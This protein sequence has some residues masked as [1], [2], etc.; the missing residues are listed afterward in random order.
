MAGSYERINFALR[1]AKNMERKMLCD[2]FRRLSEFARVDSYRYIGLGSVYFSDFSLFH[3]ALGITSALSI[4]RDTHK[5]DR[6]LFN[7]PFKCIDMRFGESNNIL[8][9]LPWDIRTILWLDYDGKLGG[10]V[11][12]DVKFFCS[13]AVSGSVI[14]VTVNAEPDDMG[15]DRLHS[16]KVDVGEEK[17][18][19]DVKLA[20]LDAWGTARIS[21]RIINNEILQTLTERNGGRP[22]GTRIK[23]KQLFNF[24]YADGAKMLTVGGLLYEEGQSDIVE[25]CGFKHLP[26]VKFWAREY[27]IE[28]PILTF[29]EFRHLDAQLP[30]RKNSKLKARSIPKRDLAKYERVYRYFPSFVEAEF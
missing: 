27:R 28:V 8:P 22:A 5:R 17:V 12:T 13:R 25:R 1:P 9:E 24:H 20:D 18:P 7:L 15:T 29:K 10:S 21:R 14:V 4:E 3:K 16:L 23:Y 30:K 6:F 11:L 26:F 2:A 19:A